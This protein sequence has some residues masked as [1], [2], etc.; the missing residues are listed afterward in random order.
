[1]SFICW[2]NSFWV[3]VLFYFWFEKNNPLYRYG[4]KFVELFCEWCHIMRLSGIISHVM[5]LWSGGS[6]NKS[7]GFSC[8][9]MIQKF[10]HALQLFCDVNLWPLVFIHSECKALKFFYGRWSVIQLQMLFFLEWLRIV[11]VLIRD[12]FIVFCRQMSRSFVAW[13]SSSLLSC[14]NSNCSLNNTKGKHRQKI[15]KKH[16]QKIRNYHVFEKLTSMT[17]STM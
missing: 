7:V 17:E 1:M 3:D 2:T 8:C 9:L 4:G 12:H 13:F 16:G 10:V 5:I 11:E 6:V 14:R 15:R